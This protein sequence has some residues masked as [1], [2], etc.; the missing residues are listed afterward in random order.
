MNA[1]RVWLEPESATYTVFSNAVCVYCCRK[2]S[3]TQCTAGTPSTPYQAHQAH[4]SCNT[5]NIAEHSVAD[6]GSSHTL[7]AFITYS[8]MP[9]SAETLPFNISDLDTRCQEDRQAVLTVVRKQNSKKQDGWRGVIRVDGE[10]DRYFGKWGSSISAAARSL[11]E[12]HSHR[13]SATEQEQLLKR[14]AGMQMRRTAS[15]HA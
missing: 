15:A 1:V 10:I 8:H 13:I 3:G 6:S 12:K 7:T 2:I 9:M 4:Q 14:V 5:Y 11:L